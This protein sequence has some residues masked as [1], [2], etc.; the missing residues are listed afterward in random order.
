MSFDYSGQYGTPGAEP[1]GQNYTEHFL[2][3]P[4]ELTTE[5]LLLNAKE[6]DCELLDP[7]NYA[8]ALFVPMKNEQEVVVPGMSISDRSSSSA[9]GGTR[10]TDK[11]LAAKR[12]AQNRAAQR[13][14]RERKE[15]KMKELEEKLT[16]S[17]TDKLELKK[18]LEDLKQQNIAITTENKILHLSPSAGTELNGSEAFSF[19]SEE[20]LYGV[21]HTLTNQLTNPQIP[22]EAKRLTIPET[23]N[24]LMEKEDS[25][26]DVD[27]VLQL[28][29]GSEVCHPQGPAYSIK[30][31]DDIVSGLLR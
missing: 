15:V 19:P 1:W 8:N 3:Q 18:Q 29:R 7:Q 16:Q 23:W 13:A 10:E 11:E 24:Y 31:I 27:S 5:N 9:H 25:R 21:H 22:Y 30:M 20:P 2:A 28:L 14:F 12:K 17:E 26:I 6:D 4:Q